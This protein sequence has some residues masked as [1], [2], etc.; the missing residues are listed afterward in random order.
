MKKHLAAC[1]LTFFLFCFALDGPPARIAAQP[2]SPAAASETTTLRLDGL[3]S[4]VLVRRDERGIPYIEAA[5]EA[6]LYYAQ[7]YVTASDRLFQMELF[8]RTARGELSEIFGNTTLEEDKRHRTLGFA[9]LSEAQ[10]QLMPPKLRRALEDYARG[11]NAYIAAHELKTLPPEFQILQLKP[12]PWRAADSLVVSKLFDESLSTTW[13]LDL[14][15]AAFSDLPAAKRDALFP[16]TS[17]H[18]VLLVGSDNAGAKPTASVVPPSS[19]DNSTQRATVGFETMRE[20]ARDER[21]MKSSLARVGF[22]AQDNAASNNWVVSG[23]HTHTGKP[24][25][26]NDPHLQASAPSIWHMVHL[27]IPGQRSAGVSVA[28]LPGIAIG[29]NSSIAWGVTSLEPDTQDLYVEKF[30]ADNPRRYQTP[31]GWRE[32]QTRREEIKVRKGFMSNETEAVSFDVTVTRH[33]PIILERDGKRYALRWTALD[34]RSN[35]LESFYALNFARNWEEFRAA[36]RDY[37]GPAFNMIYADTQGHIGYYGVGRFPIRKTGDGKLPYDGATDDGEWLGFIPFEQLPHLYDPP[38]GLIVTANSRIVG[39]S[40]PHKLTVAPLAAYRARRILELLQAKPKLTI[41]D[42]RVIQGDTRS[43]SGVT[44]VHETLKELTPTV[45]PASDAQ[46]LAHLRLLKD[47]DG[48]VVPESR[49]ALLVSHM[50]GAFRSRILT[51]AVGAERAKLYTYS[52]ADTFIDR[53]I[54][55]KPKEWL[56]AEFRSYA[57]LLRAAYAD[58]RAELTKAF[59]ADETKWTW[60]REA[61]VRFPHPLAQV[62]LIGQQFVITP[63]PQNGSTSSLTTVNRGS[64]V[65]MR[66]IA[67]PADWDRTE[68]G[69]APGISGLPSSPHWKDQ[70]D[71]W[72]NVTPRV[73]PFSPPAVAAAARETLTLEPATR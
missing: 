33:G 37:S 26:A 46:L 69:I 25:L 8:R 34:S 1:G 12:Q 58:A 48:R 59:G 17:P 57:E 42:F 60:E 72:R 50:R 4:R 63:F 40:Y 3:S 41:S 7:G 14:M 6:D 30:D 64:S 65:S 2:A 62:P 45:Q 53:L 28:G 13:R 54:T 24:L 10:V 20:L 9:Q 56:P 44:F 61:L 22:F 38:S 16:E 68:Q 35:M 36:L 49:A 23:K 73:F 43:L 21:L 66:L 11:V 31:A 51:A 70:L 55:E 19:T 71:D 32:A 27:S 15:R 39:R 67:D 47:W 52:N 29:H 18:D 5:N